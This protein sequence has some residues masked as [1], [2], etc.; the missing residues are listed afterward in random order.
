MEGDTSERIEQKQ[1]AALDTRYAVKPLRAAA[2]IHTHLYE[3]TGRSLRGGSGKGLEYFG[4][5]QGRERG[6]LKQHLLGLHQVHA[7]AAHAFLVRPQGADIA[8]V[9]T[10]LAGSVCVLD[11]L[12]VGVG[13]G[14]RAAEDAEWLTGWSHGSPALVATLVSLLLLGF[15]AG[16]AGT[17]GTPVHVRRRLLR[18]SLRASHVGLLKR[19]PERFTGA[20]EYGCDEHHSKS[21]TGYPRSSAEVNL[22]DDA[23]DS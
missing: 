3:G 12:A 15:A 18:L 4:P 7:D 14:E 17:D 19:P 5:Y 13:A 16:G 9:Q 23:P 20:F 6:L 21:R 2:F 8:L 11:A 1:L 10:R 22:P